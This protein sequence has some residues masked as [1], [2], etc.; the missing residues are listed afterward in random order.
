MDFHRDQA[1][2]NADEARIY[3]NQANT[4]SIG[5]AGMTAPASD[6]IGSITNDSIKQLR[7]LISLLASVSAGIAGSMP[8]SGDMLEKSPDTL[9]SQ[10]R[11]VRRLISE[12]NSHAQR[13]AGSL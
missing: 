4:D 6:T 13:I 12:A 1:M 9:L 3:R 2:K 7:D 8:Q 11:E 10:T 5:M